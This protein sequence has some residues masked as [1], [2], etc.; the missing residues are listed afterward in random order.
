MQEYAGEIK[1]G[2]LILDRR[3]AFDLWATKQKAGARFILRIVKDSP[4]REQSQSRAH[5]ERCGIIADEIGMT[6]EQVSDL[7]MQDAF[8]A[9][10]NPAYGKYV[11]AFG[12][13]WFIPESTTSLTRDE[14]WKL[15]AAAYERLKFLN[16][17]R[18]PSLWSGF[19]E[20]GENGV[21][22]RVCFTWSERPED[23]EPP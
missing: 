17:D 14:F 3:Q 5:F 21:V 13:E 11:K 16:E 18:D 2:K 12:K 15:K 4:G 8:D 1:G 23:M 20:R 7:L 19:P 9:T 22:L 10:Q 6:K